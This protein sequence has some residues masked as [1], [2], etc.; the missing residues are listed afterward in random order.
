[1]P[2][3]ARPDMSAY[4]VPEELDGALPWSWAEER[5]A[6]T[7]NFWLITVKASGR[8]HSMLIWGQEG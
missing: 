3:I 5:L 2:R 1:M 6:E 4:G 8:P 7:R